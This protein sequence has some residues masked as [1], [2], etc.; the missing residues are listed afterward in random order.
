VIAAAQV[1]C[2]AV[3]AMTVVGEKE[4]MATAKVVAVAV[5]GEKAITAKITT[6]AAMEKGQPK[7]VKA[8]E[9]AKVAKGNHLK[10]W[11][12]AT[13]REKV[14]RDQ[15]HLRAVAEAKAKAKAKET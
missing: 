11:A 3:E 9:R 10:A 13:E 15:A 12:R 8:K 1:F 4:K 7:E 6:V 14:E 5:A 2:L